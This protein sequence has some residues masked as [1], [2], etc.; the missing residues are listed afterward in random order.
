MNDTEK[1]K[2]QQGVLEI[3]DR[4]RKYGR[5]SEAVSIDVKLI[6]SG[7]EAINYKVM[8]A[9]CPQLTDQELIDLTFKMGIRNSV[10]LV[11]LLAVK[12]GIRM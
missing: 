12:H 1:E 9:F 6:M 11:A 4:V 8:K 5:D 2:I 3:K 7:Q 10:E